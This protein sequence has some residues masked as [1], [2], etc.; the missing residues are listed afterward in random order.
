MAINDLKLN[1][2]LDNNMNIYATCK[3]FDDLNIILSVFKGGLSANLEGY[4]V[5]LKATKPDQVPL[6]QEHTGITIA[7]NVL[8][9]TADKQLTNVAGNTVIEMQFI[10][11]TTNKKKSTYNIILQV[12]NSTLEVDGS[13]SKS[14]YTLLERLED[15]LDQAGN[16]YENM[17][18]A[19]D[20]AIKLNEASEKAKTEAEKIEPLVTSATSLK[21][22]LTTGVQ[23]GTPLN[24]E[25][26]NI[27]TQANEV[28]P[29]LDESVQKAQDFIDLNQ[30]IIGSA[31]QIAQNKKDITGLRTDVES[32]KTD[33]TGLRT[34]VESV[35]TELTTTTSTTNQNKEDIITLQVD[36]GNIKED[37]KKINEQYSVYSTQKDGDLYTVVEYKKTGDKLYCR[38]TLSEKDTQGNFKKCKVEYFYDSG[39]VEK[40]YN[41]TLTYD[42]DGIIIKKEVT[43]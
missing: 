41:W 14:T 43:Q 40:T 19:A 8:T 29:R 13:I 17:D 5:R 3:Q 27:V 37:I 33:L 7:Q 4:N 35:K 25:L 12:Y 9:I 2:E 1:I 34:D 6:I 32:V 23:A 21:N 38:S 15:K 36:N 26:K 11:K 42:D 18:K 10:D 39:E 24:S 31:E 30:T 28:K 22:E 16:F 20:I